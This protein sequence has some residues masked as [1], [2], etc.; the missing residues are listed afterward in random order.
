M[1]TDS[2]TCRALCIAGSLLVLACAASAQSV[3]TLDDAVG[4]ARRT[5]PLLQAAPARISAAE[6]NV[7]QAGL[8]PNPRLFVQTENWRGWSSPE[9]RPG[10][11]ID[12]FF[13]ASQAFE[14]GGKR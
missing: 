5:H 12:T 6:S 13:Y 7:T 9:P 8:R 3:L 11:D 4:T 2:G 10:Y 14:I 1:Q